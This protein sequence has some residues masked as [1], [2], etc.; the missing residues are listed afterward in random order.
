MTSNK[1]N[2]FR[3]SFGNAFKGFRS[4]LE[5]ERNLK[6]HIAVGMLVI[7]AGFLFRI[8]SLE[9]C[10]VLITIAA[11]VISELFNTAVEITV[12]LASRILKNKTR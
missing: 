9:W 6:I 10:I 1:N 4:A 8:S 12:D 2:G 11:V 5:T 3:S 7:I